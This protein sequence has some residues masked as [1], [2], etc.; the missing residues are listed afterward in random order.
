MV[1]LTNG[2]LDILFEPRH[3]TLKVPNILVQ[4]GGIDVS[5][6]YLDKTRGL[7]ATAA[8]TNIESGGVDLNQIFALLGDFI[9]LLWI[10]FGSITIEQHTTIAQP[11]PIATITIESDG[12][13]STIGSVTS[14]SL[15]DWLSET[16]PGNGTP[17]QCRYTS[18][19]GDPLTG[20]SL[21]NVLSTDQSFSVAAGA[22][23]ATTTNTFELEIEH[24]ATGQNEFRDITLITI[25][26]ALP[27]IL[28]S[29]LA[30]LSF[31]STQEQPIVST[32]SLTLV[33]DGTTLRAETGTVAGNWLSVADT[34]YASSFECRYTNLSG[35]TPVGPTTFTTLS[36]NVVFSLSIVQGGGVTVTSTFDVVIREI[37]NA[38]TEETR[39]VTLSSTSTGIPI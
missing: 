28:W 31:S 16:A 29:G 2:D 6:R 14:G 13:A 15:G 38:A 35:S 3:G 30:S 10:D 7:G 24:I 9:G 23:G 39:Q 19:A 1:G 20:P 26:D 4:T 8:V 11:S 32:S 18:A 21:F 22:V 36:S 12:T 33:N 37:G 27:N 25:N 5:T 34:D 17:F